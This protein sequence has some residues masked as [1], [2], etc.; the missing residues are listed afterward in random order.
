M[1]LNE[2]ISSSQVYDLVNRGE[3]EINS[4]SDR[5]SEPELA[6]EADEKR[7][8]AKSMATDSHLDK[9][10]F[11]LVAFGAV[12]HALAALGAGSK[13]AGKDIPGVSNHESF[14]VELASKYSKYLSPIPLAIN[15]IKKLS[16]P[17]NF[18]RGIAELSPLTKMLSGHVSNLPFFTG[19]LAAYNAYDKQTR[20][21]FEENPELLRHE[22]QSNSRLGHLG[23][24]LKNLKMMF[25]HSSKELNAGQDIFKHISRLL[26]VPGFG[27]PFFYGLLFGRAEKLNLFVH[28]FIRWGRSAVGMVADLDKVFN[29]KE[30]F[31]KKLGALF[32][33]DSFVNSFSPWL[34]NNRS[35]RD[36]TGN[37]SAAISETGNFFYSLYL[38]EQKDRDEKLK[39]QIAA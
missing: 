17:Q 5:H 11:G 6:N 14:F 20:E 35:A 34:E 3:P 13:V 8:I 1:K 9:A 37:I 22:A 39:T 2:T 21:F 26:V 19:F 7:E 32:F 25:K 27:L 30:A 15:A 18:W 10:K 36:T 33:L 24:I 28:K 29:A 12:S 16:Q 23:A 38:Q 4:N 31:V